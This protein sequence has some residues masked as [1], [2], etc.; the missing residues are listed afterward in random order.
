LLAVGTLEGLALDATI[1]GR[2]IL[3]GAA[4]FHVGAPTGCTLTVGANDEPTDGWTVSDPELGCGAGNTMEAVDGF[5]VDSFQGLV[6]VGSKG[7]L[8]ALGS[9]L[10]CCEGPRVGG[11]DVGP[12]RV[13][14][15][16][17]GARVAGR[18][19]AMLGTTWLGEDV[20][21]GRDGQT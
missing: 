10:N 5:K 19:G 15:T 13:G 1:D 6:V 17:D 2:C 14:A 18:E 7:L 20:A 8:V 9:W 12:G 21:A 11:G 16:A 3:V 4:L